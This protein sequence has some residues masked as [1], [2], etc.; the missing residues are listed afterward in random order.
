MAQTSYLTAQREI[1]DRFQ[2][3]W[4]TR[5]PT[6][7]PVDW[8]NK[9][10]DP[11]TGFTPAT[12]TAWVRITIRTA[13]ARQASLGGTVHRWRRSGVVLVQVFIPEGKGAQPALAVADDV[14][15]SLQGLTLNGMALRASR[16]DQ[17]ARTQDGWYQ[18]N[19][20][21]PFIYD[22]RA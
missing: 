22:V 11:A 17:P 10:F 14:V 6:D 21:T 13:D 1:L 15:A 18:V 12:H 8:P 9:R 7:C 19:V 20:T 2:S 4:A 16:I 3:Q 5:H